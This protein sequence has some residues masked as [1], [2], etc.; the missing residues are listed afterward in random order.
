MHSKVCMFEK[1]NTREGEAQY[2]LEKGLVDY[3]S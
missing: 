3:G 2:S 1:E